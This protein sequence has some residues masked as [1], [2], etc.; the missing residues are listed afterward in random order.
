MSNVALTNWAN[1]CPPESPLRR[2]EVHA[3]GANPPASSAERAK[4]LI[5]AYTSS[6]AKT[7]SYIYD[8]QHAMDIC[9]HPEVMRLHGYTT[10]VGTNPGPLMPL[11][12]FAKTSIHQDIL[13]TPL[14]QYSSSYMGYDPEWE[15]KTKNLVMWRGSSTGSENLETTEWRHS[16]RVRLHFASHEV[17]GSTK[18]W[19]SEG[20]GEVKEVKVGVKELNEAFLDTSLSGAP[21]QCDA[22]TCRVMEQEINFKPTMGLE[23]AYE[24]KYVM[25]VDGNGWS[26]RF[27]RLMSMKA[28]VLKSTLFP[29]WYSD[30]IQPWVHYVRTR[31]DP[32]AVAGASTDWLV[33][34]SCSG[35]DQDR[36]L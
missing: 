18:L 27:H 17:K 29:E 9:R 1:G 7:R 14:E 19:V 4:V 8:H 25:D 23:E 15:R 22:R 13:A 33:G 31:G 11:F 34:M 28:L 36:L 20:A 16:Q 3:L 21:V 26:G 35:P 10:A 6:L 5:E 24:Y 12:T 30:R 2:A 32:F